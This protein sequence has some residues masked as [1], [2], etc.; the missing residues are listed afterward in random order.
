M[1]SDLFSKRLNQLL[2][3]Q[4]EIDLDKKLSP[5][6]QTSIVN[7]YRA[8]Q[9]LEEDRERELRIQEEKRK[10]QINNLIRNKT[11]M[12][13]WKSKGEVEWAKNMQIQKERE[14]RDHAFKLM[15]TM[16]EQQKALTVQTKEREDVLQGIEAFEANAGKLGID[17]KHD[18]NQSKKAERSTFS[19]TGALNKLMDAPLQSEAVR[20]ERDKRYFQKKSLLIHFLKTKKDDRRSG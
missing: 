20:K 17:L 18:P 3:A 5:F 13:D 7:E 11:F 15:T 8:R 10:M 1:E 19:G 9:Q 16:K 4:K 6:R 2:P 12:E 14:Q